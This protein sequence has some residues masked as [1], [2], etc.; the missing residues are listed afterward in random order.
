MIAAVHLVF[1]HGLTE[2]SSE[3]WTTTLDS[4]KKNLK[5]RLAPSCLEVDFHVHLP[6]AGASPVTALGRRQ[7]PAWFDMPV[8]PLTQEAINSSMAADPEFEGS[9]QRVLDTV[10]DV[11]KQDPRA[12]IVL[13][14]FSQG[15]AL[16]LSAGVRAVRKNLPVLGLLCVGGWHV[17]KQNM[18]RVE[19]KSC[20]MEEQRVSV[21]SLPVLWLHGA[22]D[23]PIPVE[24]CHAGLTQLR[25]ARGLE[26]CSFLVKPEMGHDLEDQSRFPDEVTEWMLKDVLASQLGGKRDGE[27]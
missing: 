2:T 23:R 12:L 25:D 14:G 22:K 26:K 7:V 3:K 27:L 13:G 16:A 9:V 6:Q 4:L 17:L 21:S 18:D 19:E 20:G 1:L 24:R 10:H 11:L 5:E 8:I 15:G